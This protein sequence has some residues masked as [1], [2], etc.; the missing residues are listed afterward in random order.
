MKN[1]KILFR[2]WFHSSNF[3]DPKYNS[4]THKMIMSPKNT[5][6]SNAIV[7]ILLPT[8][9]LQ[10]TPETDTEVFFWNTLSEDNQSASEFS[11]VC[12]SQ[13]SQN[14]PKTRFHCKQKTCDTWV[15]QFLQKAK[16]RPENHRILI[17]YYNYLN[18]IQDSSKINRKF[19]I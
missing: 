16:E 9:S 5:I 12:Q 19:F 7:C 15:S 2:D 14:F 4:E 6:T 17:Y 13:F 1:K 8:E 11:K 10:M 18:P 3:N